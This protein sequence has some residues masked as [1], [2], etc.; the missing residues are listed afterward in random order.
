MANQTETTITLT[1]ASDDGECAV[2]TEGLHACNEAQARFSDSRAVA[3]LVHDP[4]TQNV[5]GGLLVRTSLG[6]LRV[7]RFFCQRVFGVAVSAAGCS[8]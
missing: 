3:I 4:K 7:E 8:L 2:I 1:D 6:L 5:V